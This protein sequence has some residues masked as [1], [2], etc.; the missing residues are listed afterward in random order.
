MC[1]IILTVEIKRAT[2]HEGLP[3]IT[4]LNAELE[5][6]YPEPGA[7]HFQ[8]DENEVAPGRG[9]FLIARDGGIALGCGAIRLNEYG[10]EVKRMYT[11]PAARG[12][13][14]GRAILDGLEKEARALGATRMILETGTR[15]LAAIRLYERAGFTK[16]DLYG[17]YVRSPETSYCMARALV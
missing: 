12:R 13:G 3:L 1:G 14:V 17:E 16:I 15:Q 8:L 5:V 11:A 9:C 4:A 6:M 7:N 2:L 10:A